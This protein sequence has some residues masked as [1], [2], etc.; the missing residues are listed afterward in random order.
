MKAAVYYNNNDI[1]IEDIPQPKINEKQILVKVHS[2]GICGSDVV[3]WYRLPRAPLVQG[4]EMS[5][6]VVEVGSLVKNYKVG[7]R[8]FIAPKVGCGKCK[9]CQKS[10]H[11]VCPNVKA[12]LPGAFTEYVLVPEELIENA[13]FLIPDKLSYDAA[14]FIEPLACAIRA[15]KFSNIKKEDSVLVIGSGMSG[16]LH[17]KLALNKGAKVTAIDINEN[18]LEFAKKLGAKAINAKNPPSEKFDVVILCTASLQAFEQAW[19]SVDL[20]GVIVLFTVPD[21]DKKVIVPVNDFWRKEV[22]IITSYYCGPD[23]LKE[24]LNLISSGEI[25][26]KDMITHRLPLDEIQKGFNLVL[27]GKESIKVIINP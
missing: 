27:D 17:I 18:K 26:V 8:V 6:E 14:T 23:N 3:E 20:G 10:H 25:K 9:Y 15:Q 4:H 24:S 7:D 21:P 16:L 12:R 5:G 2:C 11:S 13:V 1:R 22:K 19:K